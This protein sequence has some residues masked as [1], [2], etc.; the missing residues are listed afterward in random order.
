MTNEYKKL[1]SNS[2]IEEEF[3][4]FLE[5]K[6][7]KVISFDIF[8]TLAFRKVANPVDIF[9]KVGKDNYV[10]DIFNT[11]DTFKQF[12]I[13]AEQTARSLNKNLEDITFDLIYEQLP[14]TSKQKKKIQK[15]ELE[16][17]Y[18][19]LYINKQIE[20]WIEKAY[21]RGKKVILI[22]DMY[23]SQKHI[24]KVILSK[25]TN[26]HLISKDYVS[27]EYGKSKSKG[28]LFPF[29]RNDLKINY[30]QWLHIGDNKHSDIIQAK[31]LNIF[32][33]HYKHNQALQ[34]TFNIEERYINSNL[35]KLSSLRKITTLLNPYREKKEHF[36]FNLA[37]TVYGP[38]LWSFSHWLNDLAK[39]EKITQIN[40][41]M[42]EG[43]TFQ[44]YLHKINTHI[45]TN[46]IYASRKSIFLASLDV[47]TF[48]LSDFN[49]SVY[50]GIRIKDLY[51]FYNI[52]L[53]NKILIQYEDTLCSNANIIRIENSTLLTV[54]ENDL[55][56]NLSTIKKHIKKNK[57]LF[58]EYLDS[59]NI[60]DSSI[61]VD[62]GG[63]GTVLEHISKTLDKK[64]ILNILFYKHHLGYKK[65]LSYKT[66][67]F[68]HPSRQTE[69]A[70]NLIKRTPEFTEILLNGLDQTTTHYIKK[71]EKVIPIT[72]YPYEID[73]FV[74]IVEAF[75]KGLD[76][77]FTAVQEYKFKK[78]INNNILAMLI[79]RI[80][81]VPS[82]DEVEHL[83]NLYYDEG[84][85]SKLVQKLI[86]KN[87]IDEITKSDIPSMYKAYSENYWYKRNKY[88]W[89]TGIISKIDPSYIAAI[90]GIANTDNI[91]MHAMI[92]VNILKE[93]NISKINIYGA[94]GL[95]SKLKHYLKES[96]IEIISIMDK[97]ALT[98]EFEFEGYTITSLPYQLNN[99]NTYPILVASISY[100][101][102]ITNYLFQFIIQ[103]DLNIQLI[104][105][106]NGL[107][108]V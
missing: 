63:S 71:E 104:N 7:I 47:D 3:D 93:N 14:L 42:R 97:K 99:G 43:K 68:L 39:K 55:E 26:K 9:Y 76:S 33:L 62:F 74:P 72:S 77:F 108:K 107:I 27:S 5:N 64:Y 92:L 84:K 56:N 28:G 54:L 29:V 100:E 31:K 50:R 30:K 13:S 12:R 60:K 32:T 66:Y 23:L 58:K 10:K 25:L 102:E 94:G 57:K 53:T 2:L 96:N 41:I 70:I 101:M 36:F 79:A 106:T 16:E 8:D 95:I 17:E 22:S 80:I 40:F 59:F 89:I 91:D 34:D 105:R 24:N 6:D 65:M 52:K 48:T 51:S 75:H 1:C 4:A 49:A 82:K 61:F 21:N 44:K 19:S 11:A 103:K 38:A 46:L 35:K 98:K 90:K 69:N 87:L 78:I 15:L 88:N 83:G 67:S 81:E 85:G 20:N 73:S 86:P 45:D 18:K 37:V